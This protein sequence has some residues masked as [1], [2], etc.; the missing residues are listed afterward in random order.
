MSLIVISCFQI[1]LEMTIFKITK[2]RDKETLLLIKGKWTINLYIKS[3]LNTLDKN[4]KI[5]TLITIKEIENTN[6]FGDLSFWAVWQW[7]LTMRKYLED[8]KFQSIV[9]WK[10]PAFSSLHTGSFGN[11]NS[12]SEHDISSVNGIV[13]SLLLYYLYP[14]PNFKMLLKGS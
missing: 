10:G 6:F 14:P 3:I 4:A 1:L 5:L 13:L 12:C 8:K 7:D 11:Q 2:F 9:Q